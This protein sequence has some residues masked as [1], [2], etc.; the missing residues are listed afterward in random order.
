MK[1]ENEPIQP[2]RP[3]NDIDKFMDTPLFDALIESSK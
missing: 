3:Q 1:N 2:P